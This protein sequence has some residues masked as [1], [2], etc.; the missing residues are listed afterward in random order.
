[1]SLSNTKAHYLGE[2]YRLNGVKDS[3]STSELAS[4]L[5]VTPAAVARMVSRLESDGYVDRELYKGVKLTGSGEREALREIR[6]HR[7]AEAFLVRVMGYGWHE[8]HDMADALAEVADD[9]FVQRMD[10]LAGYPQTC[11]HGEPIPT[12]EGE[13]A[14]IDDL[15]LMEFE[16]GKVGLISRVQVRDEARLEYLAQI[17]LFP[18][19][20]F[21]IEARAPFGGPVRIRVGEQEHVLGA[22]I[23]E[24]VSVREVEG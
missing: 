23:A 8:A 2:I 14:A 13:I 24:K 12:A 16:T 5:Q 3:V 9:L 15:P 11:P 17:G 21:Q 20:P 4:V 19:T 1:M 10:S 22:E 18:G 7:L 6:R